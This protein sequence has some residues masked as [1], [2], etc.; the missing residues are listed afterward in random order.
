MC[1]SENDSAG[2]DEIEPLDSQSGRGEVDRSTVTTKATR[3]S[4]CT[5]SVILTSVVVGI[6]ILVGRPFDRATCQANSAVESESNAYGIPRLPWKRLPDPS[7]RLTRVAFGSCASQK[8]PQPYWDTLARIK[9]DLVLMMG[10]NVYGDCPADDTNCEDLKQAYRDFA[11]LPSVVGAAPRLSVMATLDNH[12]YSKKEAD[13]SNVHKDL[14]RELFA[15]FFGLN[16]KLPSDGVY[17]SNVF[18]DSGHSVQ[19]IMLDTRYSRSTLLKDESKPFDNFY[20]MAD[21]Q[22]Q[23]MLSERQW[24]WLQ[25]QL[26]VPAQVRLIVSSI[27]VL[28]TMTGEQ[29]WRHLPKER[30]RLLD[31]LAA[32]SGTSLLLSGDRHVGGYY[33]FEN[34]VEI[35]A[36]SWTHTVTLDVAR[37]CNGTSEDCDEKD[38]TRDGPWIRDNHFGLIDIDWD[39]RTLLVTLR[40]TESTDGV[41]YRRNTGLE[42]MQGDDGAVLASRTYSI[43]S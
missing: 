17:H 41:V 13:A 18:G 21:S 7:F 1:P 33:Q 22:T 11:E 27:Q 9:P 26:R 39:K 12:D 2:D 23:T 16:E 29:A 30:S 24:T 19:V 35:T 34:H 42:W 3:I 38:E 6:A 14:A 32:S 37:G 15:D 28:N 43:T 10:D 31:L 36:S 5:V 40:R 25:E 8:M 20:P 4:R